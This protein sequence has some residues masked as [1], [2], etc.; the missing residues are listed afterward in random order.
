MNR[1]REILLDAIEACNLILE[2]SHGFD[3]VRFAGDRK[4][5]SSVLYQIAILGETANSLSPN[6]AAANPHIPINAIRG[7]RN[8]IIHEY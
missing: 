5:Q 3:F 6:F 4:T 1:D 7:M 8:R 2:F